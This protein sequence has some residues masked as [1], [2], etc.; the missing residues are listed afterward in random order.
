MAGLIS[1]FLFFILGSVIVLYGYKAYVRPARFFEQLGP[2]RDLRS[3]S[4]APGGTR[5]AVRVIEQIGATVPVSK[6]NS[7]LARRYLAAA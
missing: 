2:E 7:T 1:L 3:Q 5:A 6:E 4:A